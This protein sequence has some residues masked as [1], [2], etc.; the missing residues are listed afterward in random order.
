MGIVQGENEK[1]YPTVIANENVVWCLQGDHYL[2]SNTEN[3]K[4]FTSLLYEKKLII[5]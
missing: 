5:F 3:F 2:S 4:N 1:R